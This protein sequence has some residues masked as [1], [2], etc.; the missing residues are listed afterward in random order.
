MPIE[1]QIHLAQMVGLVCI[2]P[3]VLSLAGMIW[4][5]ATH[6]PWK[7][8]KIIRDAKNAVPKKRTVLCTVPE[9]VQRQLAELAF[10]KIP[11]TWR[12]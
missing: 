9:Q 6:P 5:A 2:A 1:Q 12:D 11:A 4:L 3:A 8:R 10:P 7:M